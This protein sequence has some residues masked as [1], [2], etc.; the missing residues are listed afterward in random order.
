MSLPNSSIIHVLD[1]YFNRV[2]HLLSI[3]F[4]SPRQIL[5]LLEIGLIYWVDLDL[6]FNFMH[7]FARN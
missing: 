2:N 4:I 3:S 6:D 1:T 7:M 5:R